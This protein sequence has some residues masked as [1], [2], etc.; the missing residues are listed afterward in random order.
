MAI[1][2]V[3]LPKD[4]KKEF[5]SMFIKQLSF[6]TGDFVCLFTCASIPTLCVRPARLQAAVRPAVPEKTSTINKVSNLRPAT[7]EEKSCKN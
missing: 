2:D 7:R 5:N 6:K 1:H 3:V 4:P